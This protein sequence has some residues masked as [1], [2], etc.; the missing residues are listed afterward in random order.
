MEVMKLYEVPN[1]TH[2]KVVGGT[3]EVFFF[4]HPDGMYSVCND[5]NGNLVHLYIMQEVEIAE[6]F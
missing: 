3:D 5:A 6:G 1:K 4:D 2:V